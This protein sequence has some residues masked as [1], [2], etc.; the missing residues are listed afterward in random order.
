MVFVLRKLTHADHVTHERVGKA[1]IMFVGGEIRNRRVKMD[2][3]K[4]NRA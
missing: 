4:K 3:S 1:P 2:F